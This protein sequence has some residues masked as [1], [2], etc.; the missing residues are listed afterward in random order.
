[1]RFF[2]FLSTCVLQKKRIPVKIEKGTGGLNDVDISWIPQE[3][4]NAMSMFIFFLTVTSNNR[5]ILLL[6]SMKIKQH[7]QLIFNMLSYRQ[8]FP[9]NISTET[10]QEGRWSR[11]VIPSVFHPSSCCPSGFQ[12]SFP[13]HSN[14]IPIHNGSA[15]LG[16][17]FQPDQHVKDVGFH[18][19]S[20]MSLLVSRPENILDSTAPLGARPL[21][22]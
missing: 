19:L 6:V 1:M 13:H 17:N 16:S 20:L 7:K 9:E 8:G 5:L 3:T 12:S 21:R 11:S 4:L 22:H 2:C 18:P 15:F 14:P 10:N